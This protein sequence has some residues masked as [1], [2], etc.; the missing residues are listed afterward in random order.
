MAIDW[1][2][3][4][5][6]FDAAT[7]GDGRGS[8]QLLRGSVS[9]T[10]ATNTLTMTAHQL[11]TGDIIRLTASVPAELATARDY[12][13]IRTNANDFKVADTH[14]LAIAGTAIGFT[15]DGSGT[16][17]VTHL[18][19]HPYPVFV[20]HITV[21][22]G[23]T[24]GAIEVHDKLG[25]QIIVDIPNMSINDAVWWDVKGWVDG[26]YCTT[27]PATCSVQVYL[28]KPGG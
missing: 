19:R 24:G 27:L 13:V 8:A 12:F 3:N 1:S 16:P 14:A 15:D 2:A 22:S 9:Y 28:G 7:Q 4:R 11:N 6:V 23:G 25:G 5:W 10:N 17:T 21:V 26:I 20:D 18:P